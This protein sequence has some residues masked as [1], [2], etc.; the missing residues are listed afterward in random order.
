MIY[1]VRYLLIAMTPFVICMVSEIY[2]LPLLK[3]AKRFDLSKQLAGSLANSRNEAVN[4]P[5][6]FFKGSWTLGGIGNLP[7]HVAGPLLF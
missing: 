1:C 7:P 4:M 5:M 2:I 6:P 3:K